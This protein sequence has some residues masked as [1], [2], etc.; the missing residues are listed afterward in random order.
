M[1]IASLLALIVCL[2][3]VDR[4]EGSWAILVS[5]NNE[6]VIEVPLSNLPDNVGEGDCVGDV[7]VQ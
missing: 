4:I 5:E 1:R 2:W 7:P 6:E 3:I